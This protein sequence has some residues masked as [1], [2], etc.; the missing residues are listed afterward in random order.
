MEPTVATL[1]TV[2]AVLALVTLA[3]DLGLPKP[4]APLLAVIL[5]IGVSVA[6]AVANHAAVYPA[7]V[8][9]TLLGLGA[10]GVYDTAKVVAGHHRADAPG[11]GRHEA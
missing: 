7:V 9:G 11:D 3:K 2:P 1:A 5:G 6:D 8:A 10:A 4:L